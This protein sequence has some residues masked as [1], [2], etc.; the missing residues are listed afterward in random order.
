MRH[1]ARYTLVPWQILDSD[2][3]EQGEPE[4]VRDLHQERQLGLH[5]LGSCGVSLGLIAI[6]CER[7]G[8]TLT[9]LTLSIPETPIV[10]EPKPPVMNMARLNPKRWAS[11]D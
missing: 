11:A 10:I 7:K 2:L 3:V 9:P 6:R 8:E 5:V 1:P 4:L